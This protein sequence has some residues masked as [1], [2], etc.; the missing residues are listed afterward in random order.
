MP[1]SR[2]CPRRPAS[3]GILRCG[4]FRLSLER[5]LIMGV[6][7]TTP[8]SFSDGGRFFDPGHAL[9]H[10][11]RLI[12]EGADLLDIGGESSRPGAQVVSLEEE[13]ARVLPLLGA[14]RDSPIPVSIDTTKP[15][16]MRAAID[17]GAAMINDITAL[18]APGAREYI[19]SSA[20]VAVC[21]MHMKG[22]PRTMQ[23]A[24]RYDDVVS[25][26]FAFLAARVAMAEAAGIE[27][28]RLVIDPGFGFGKTTAHN[29][30][31]LSRL[32]EFNETG[33]PV[34]AGVSRK[35]FL[36]NLTGK[37]VG[38]RLAA[39]IAA[40]VL[41]AERGARIIRVHDVD[42]TRDALAVLNALMDRSC[43]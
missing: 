36:G 11:L 37:A 14:L 43:P 42:A 6:V 35:S 18:S 26:V 28:D 20:D 4:R 2:D 17:A 25:E 23:L 22:Q 9:E 7:N 27:R 13:L 5:P 21:L 8:D 39:S 41:A 31:L 15:A 34:L 32:A 1:F 33:L 10:A 12:E 19:A 3:G 16:V 40:A 24:P 29:L 30:E 38:G